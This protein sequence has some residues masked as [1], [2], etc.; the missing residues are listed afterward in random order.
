MS[1]ASP[2]AVFATVVALTGSQLDH[3]RLELIVSPICLAIL[4]PWSSLLPVFAKVG[5]AITKKVFL[6]QSC[7]VLGGYFHAS[8]FIE[9]KTRS[10]RG[11]VKCI[12]SEKAIRKKSSRR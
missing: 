5:P 4:R 10:F 7:G 6:G 11:K 9:G 3:D 8:V 1:S 12:I 2:T